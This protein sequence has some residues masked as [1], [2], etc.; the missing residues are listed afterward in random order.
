MALPPTIPTS[1]V[2]HAPAGGA[3]RSGSGFA[4][5]FATVAYSIL[6][7]AFILAVGVFI[8]GRML[9]STQSSKDAELYKAQSNID[10]ATVEGFVRLRDR[11]AS[12]Q[13]LMN[14]HDALSNFFSVLV[15]VLPSSVR[16]SSVHLSFGNDGAPKLEGSG[17]AKSFNALAS[18]STAFAKDGRIK[19]AIFSKITVNKDNSVSFS[20]TATLDPKLVAFSVA[21][22]AT[23]TSAVSTTTSI[24]AASTTQPL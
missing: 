7:I 5:A 15:K 8:Y 2:P 17:V 18:A 1:F 16:V 13:T 10:V 6:G 22:I 21:P 4:G 24:I 20:L 3:Q 11:L 9:A 12:G 14:G 19:G 23:S